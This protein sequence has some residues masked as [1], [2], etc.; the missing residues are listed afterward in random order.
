M[1]PKGHGV[2]KGCV[3]T[4]C[5]RSSSDSPVL[6]LSSK[7][8]SQVLTRTALKFF[9]PLIQEMLIGKWQAAKERATHAS[10]ALLK[11]TAECFPSQQ[12]FFPRTTLSCVTIPFAKYD[13]SQWKVFWSIQMTCWLCSVGRACMDSLFDIRVV[14]KIWASSELKWSMLPAMNTIVR[15]LG[16]AW[17]PLCF[18]SSLSSG[19]LQFY[20]QVPGFGSCLSLLGSSDSI[21][22][23]W[24]LAWSTSPT[25]N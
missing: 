20:W 24:F 14:W 13:Q 6:P 5:F 16:K 1:Q 25:F 12:W 7:V 15:E 8:Y 22:K 9:L 11:R 19:L 2:S 10:K 4:A 18:L 3:C 21:S 17:K 23:E